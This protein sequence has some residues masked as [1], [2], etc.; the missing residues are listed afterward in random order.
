VANGNL[1]LRLDL[2]MPEHIKTARLED[3]LGDAGFAA[4]IRL[5]CYTGKHHRSG[6]LAD[7]TPTEIER[8]SRWKGKAGAFHAALIDFRFM[9][10]P[11]TIHDWAEEQDH[12]AG[13]DAYVAAAK[14][15][16][17]AGGIRSAEVRAAKANERGPSRAP[18]NGG[19]E[20]PKK[21]AKRTPP[22]HPPVVPP[23]LPS[24]RPTD[25]GG[26]A[27]PPPSLRSGRAE[28]TADEP[29][30]LAAATAL[31]QHTGE[32]HKSCLTAVA[33]LCAA[34][35]SPDDIRREIPKVDADLGVWAAKR[36]IAT[37]L[38]LNGRAEYHGPAT[39]DSGGA[40][41]AKVQADRAKAESDLQA[42]HASGYASRAEYIR[43]RDA[44]TLKPPPPRILEG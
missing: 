7:M 5:W 24:Y 37:A 17:R 18:L 21:R 31:A 41:A 35:A 19:V 20:S 2:S 6:V 26:A 27:E 39:P 16:G 22:F 10:D 42:F 8:V 11:V 32:P 44:G 4:L 38:G 23:T 12:L 14:D 3:R 15:L 9:D 43:D 1:D 13:R 36:V 33:E 29:A 28:P 40:T 30:N 34:G 25:Q